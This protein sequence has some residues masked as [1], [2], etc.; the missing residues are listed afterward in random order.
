MPQKSTEPQWPERKSEPTD[1]TEI[2]NTILGHWF[3]IDLEGRTP[4]AALQRWF[5]GKFHGN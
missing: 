2:S 1:S 4:T 3:G 5:Y